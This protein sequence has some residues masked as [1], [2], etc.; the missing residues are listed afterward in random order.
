MEWLNNTKIV[1][2]VKARLGAGMRGIELDND[3]IAK[4]LRDE[5]LP[6]LSIYFPRFINYVIDMDEDQVGRQKGLYYVEWPTQ[7]LG[8]EIITSLNGV[9]N[10]TW[11]DRS[12]S[13]CPLDFIMSFMQK[14]ITDFTTVPFTVEFLP[15]NQIQINP[16]PPRGTMNKIAV[17]LKVA[18]ADF[19]QFA[20]GLR[21]IILKMATYDVK[22]DILGFRRIFSNISTSMA[23]IELTMGTFEEAESK[24]DELIEKIRGQAHLSANRRKIYV[25][26]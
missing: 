26:Q 1:N 6:T 4:V 20:P 11:Y 18:H 12:F 23:D 13:I 16:N 17:K 10:A 9:S 15:P 7:I 8:A 21:E 19:A 22:L 3:S 14:E 24:R 25:D 5:T 2:S